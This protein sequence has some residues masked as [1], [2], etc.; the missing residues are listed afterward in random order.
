MGRVFF[1]NTAL[2]H[3]YLDA[4]CGGGIDIFHLTSPQF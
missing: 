1:L 3:Y 4:H 2:L